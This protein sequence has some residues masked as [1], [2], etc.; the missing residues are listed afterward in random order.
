[1]W[2][3]LYRT[4]FYNLE[5]QLEQW[6]CSCKLGC[7]A[8]SLLGDLLLLSYFLIQ[9]FPSEL[10]QLNLAQFYQATVRCRQWTAQSTFASESLPVQWHH[11]VGVQGAGYYGNYPY[12]KATASR[13]IDCCQGNMHM[14]RLHVHQERVPCSREQSSARHKLQA[15]WRWCCIIGLYC[16]DLNS[17]LLSC[18]AKEWTCLCRERLIRCWRDAIGLPSISL[19]AVKDYRLY[20]L[21]AHI[22]A[23][24]LY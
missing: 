14:H 18:C 4:Y 12:A 10:K 2:T 13:L 11:I 17:N 15:E 16:K 20:S 6:Y 3:T 23:H 5:V 7:A 8:V 1:M 24:C 9:S 22:A 19:A 21:I